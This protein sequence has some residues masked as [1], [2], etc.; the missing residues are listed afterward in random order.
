MKSYCKRCGGL[1]LFGH[2]HMLFVIYCK[3]CRRV[4]W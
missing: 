4:K 2:W 3:N 1:N